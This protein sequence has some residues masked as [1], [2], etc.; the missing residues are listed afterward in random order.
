[1]HTFLDS[2]DSLF[3]Y[4]RQKNQKS[5]SSFTEQLE[6]L[7]CSSMLQELYNS[8]PSTLSHDLIIHP[9]IS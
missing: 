1:M 8:S 3:N 2:A 5:Y 4:Q 7:N 9:S 6:E